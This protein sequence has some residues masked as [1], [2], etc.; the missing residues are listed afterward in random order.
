[1]IVVESFAAGTAPRHRP[2]AL[3][4]AIRIDTS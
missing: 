2:S 4:A 1:M 3:I